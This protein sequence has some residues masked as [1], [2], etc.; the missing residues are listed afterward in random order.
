MT[1]QTPRRGVGRPKG[2]VV[3]TRPY[4]VELD[5][6]LVKKFRAR[7]DDLSDGIRTLGA[8]HFALLAEG[9]AQLRRLL[10]DN[11]ERKKLVTIYRNGGEDALRRASMR[12]TE[13]QK[14]ALLDC[15]ERFC[16][17]QDKDVDVPL[18][19]LLK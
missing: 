11:I 15:I 4:Q 8:R 5:T 18:D 9:R 2:S 12:F 13:F 3:E 16:A 17:A 1:T 6:D 14:A 7:G 10:K 19:V